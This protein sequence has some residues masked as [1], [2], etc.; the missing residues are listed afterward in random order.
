MDDLHWAWGLSPLAPLCPGRPPPAPHHPRVCGAGGRQFTRREPPTPCRLPRCQVASR[1][2]LGGSANFTRSSHVPTRTFP[3]HQRRPPPDAEIRPEPA[4]RLPT[5]IPRAKGLIGLMPRQN[6][7]TSSSP[8]A[9][10]HFPPLSPLWR[11]SGMGRMRGSGDGVWPA[12]PA[13]WHYRPRSFGSV[14]LTGQKIAE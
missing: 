2:R 10:D 7:T 5:S 14:S 13:A 11:P 3:A 4:C 12:R 9:A 6:S 1:P 8:L